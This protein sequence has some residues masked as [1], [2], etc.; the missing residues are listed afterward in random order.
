MYR[1]D[2]P[3]PGVTGYLCVPPANP[4]RF[5][6]ISILWV[7]NVAGG[8]DQSVLDRH[9]SAVNTIPRPGRGRKDTGEQ[10]L[11]VHCKPEGFV[12]SPSGFG[13]ADPLPL[14]SS[15]SRVFRLIG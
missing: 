5:H 11:P 1:L 3:K 12:Y 6:R 4:D 9:A 15:G 8:K 2:F 7:D 10:V 14:T 13:G